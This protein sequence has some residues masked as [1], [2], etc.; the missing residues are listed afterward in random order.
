MNWC[1]VSIGI[2]A[3]FDNIDV[4]GRN[5]LNIIGSNDWHNY[6]IHLFQRSM[7]YFMTSEID[8]HKAFLSIS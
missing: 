8:H 3:W 4:L 6:A 1:L 2:L 5:N 7:E